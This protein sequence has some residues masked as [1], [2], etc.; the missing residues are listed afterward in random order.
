[1][2]KRDAYYCRFDTLENSC[3]LDLGMNLD[4]DEKVHVIK[5]GE[6]N[7]AL[8]AE[9]SNS[10]Y[11]YDRFLFVFRITSRKWTI[12]SREQSDEC[13][14]SD[15]GS[16]P[17]RGDVLRNHCKGENTEVITDVVQR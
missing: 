4:G 7:M 3:H 2:R 16:P 8:V 9:N 14:Q 13:L 10:I 17:W 12:K 1:M 11:C 6:G 5:Y 15:H